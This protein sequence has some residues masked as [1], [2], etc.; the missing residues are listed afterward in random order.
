MADD[1]YIKFGD[2][3][4]EIKRICNSFIGKEIIDTSFI[5]SE[6]SSFYDSLDWRNH[7][8][9]INI[10]PTAIIYDRTD[11]NI[12]GIDE[13]SAN[14]GSITIISYKTKPSG[15]EDGIIQDIKVT[16]HISEFNDCYLTDISQIL[17]YILSKKERK[18]IIAK[19][20]KLKQQIQE[21]DKKINTLEKIMKINA[22]DETMLNKDLSN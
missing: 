13:Y 17:D 5:S 10:T 19:N 11:N 22:Y 3:F 6:I 16:N 9:C 4:T 12:E 20:E 15:E 7:L 14:T 21:N 1:G 2:F 18:K 8:P